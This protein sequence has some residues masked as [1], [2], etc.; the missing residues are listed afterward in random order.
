[1][2]FE[3]EFA[4]PEA[5]NVS[6]DASI[7]GGEYFVGK[8]PLSSGEFSFDNERPGFRVEIAPF[9]ISKTLV[10]NGEFLEFLEDG[11][12]KDESLWDFGGRCW[13]ADCPE[14]VR[15]MPEYW[16]RKKDGSFEY[17]KF[18]RW[19][20]L[21]LEAPALHLSVFEAEAFCRWAGRWLPTEPEWEAAARGPGALDFP[22]GDGEVDSSRLDMDGTYFG[23]ASA[24]AFKE[25]ASES[26]CL[27][28]LGTAWEWTS[29]Q[30]LPYAG[31]EI[32][33]YHYMSVLQFGDHR[34]TKGG[35]CATCSG[36]IRNS[37]RQA[38]LPG[39]TDVFTGFLTCAR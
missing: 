33:M 30:F 39:R 21:S 3:E 9:Q 27:Q 23:M 36:L 5:F 34:V 26:G 19:R 35:S 37:Y 29:N 18:D 1:M 6:G 14:E 20:E 22:W 12:C 8:P 31:F 24:S 15:G 11:G 10:T 25:G 2:L 38:Y 28:M 17:R 32:D 4:P 16:R 7:G 13:L